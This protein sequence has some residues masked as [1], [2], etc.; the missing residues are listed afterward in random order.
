[1]FV[2]IIAAI[3]ILLTYLSGFNKNMP[4]YAV[5]TFFPILPTYFAFNLGDSLPLL[6]AYRIIV[7]YFFAYEIL[8]NKK[9]GLKEVF[10]KLRASHV[11]KYIWIYLMAVVVSSI[12]ANTGDSLKALISILLENVL[13]FYFLVKRFLDPEVF[14][15]AIH[16]LIITAFIL[17]L[18]GLIEGLSGF[19][20]FSLLD[21]KVRDNIVGSA[22]YERMGTNRVESSFGHPIGFGLYLTLM[23]PLVLYS[24]NHGQRLALITFFLLIINLLLTI[25]RGPLIAFLVVFMIYLLVSNLKSK[26]IAFYLISVFL[27]S[28]G[29]YCTNVENKLTKLVKNIPLSIISLVDQKHSVRNFGANQDPFDYR[30]LI[31]NLAVEKM[32][33]NYWFGLGMGYFRTHYFGQTAKYGKIFSIDNNYLLNFLEL[34]I[35]GALAIILLIFKFLSLCLA[36]PQKRRKLD[37][38]GFYLFL[39]L[40]GYYLSLT[41]VAALNSDRILWVFLA[42]VA[43]QSLPKSIHDEPNPENYS[44]SGGGESL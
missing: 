15:K 43:V 11:N 31:V 34:G 30:L 27:I 33:N 41:T 13:L 21:L 19:N 22:M 4:L 39:S 5:V 6:T 9:P 26:L 23:L 44:L 36:G 18:L 10:A 42:L 3:I 25:S 24:A 38:I 35:I 20:I 17:G 32:K 29:L 14:D 37:G 8:I 7:I 1:M 16:I 2:I 12:M 40:L 28:A